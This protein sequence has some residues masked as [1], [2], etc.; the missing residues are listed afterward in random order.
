MIFWGHFWC[1]T[2]CDSVLLSTVYRLMWVVT[3]R[4]SEGAYSLP[5]KTWGASKGAGFRR[6]RRSWTFTQWVVDLQRSLLK[7]ALGAEGSPG[8]NV[9]K[10][11]SHAR[12]KA[13]LQMNLVGGGTATQEKA[14]MGILLLFF[15]RH[16]LVAVF[17]EQTVPP[18]RGPCREERL[19]VCSHLEL[20]LLVQVLIYISD[21]HQTFT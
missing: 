18:E 6:S 12:L 5:H 16:P 2:F 7:G 13:S 21:L 8:F 3:E 15:A 10:K 17:G 9:W 11:T 4:C 19:L 20:K 1:L 14:H